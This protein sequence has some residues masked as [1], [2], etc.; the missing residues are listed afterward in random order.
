[1]KLKRKHFDLSPEEK[2][3]LIVKF[4]HFMHNKTGSYIHFQFVLMVQIHDEY[5]SFHE[6]HAAFIPHIQMEL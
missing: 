5:L 6:L 4:S 1:M 3:H 2:L